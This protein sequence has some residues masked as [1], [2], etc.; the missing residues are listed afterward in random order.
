[1]KCRYHLCLRESLM[2]KLLEATPPPSK[3][4]CRCNLQA[5]QGIPCRTGWKKNNGFDLLLS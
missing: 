3:T 4:H 2:H 5:L 1:M